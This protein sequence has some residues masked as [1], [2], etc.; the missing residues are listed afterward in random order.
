MR[1]GTRTLQSTRLHD[2][3]WNDRQYTAMYYHV[4]HPGA[5]TRKDR[6]A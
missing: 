3:R 5:C 2:I 1:A 6:G 4:D